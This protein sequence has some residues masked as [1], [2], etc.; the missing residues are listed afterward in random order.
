ML[1]TGLPLYLEKP[2]IREILK[3]TWNID[4]K[5]WIN[6]EFLTILK[7]LI[8]KFRFDKKNLSYK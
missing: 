2:G 4:Q 6:L 5:T 7:F 3:K 1:I 8:V